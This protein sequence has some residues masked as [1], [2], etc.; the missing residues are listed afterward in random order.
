[1]TTIDCSEIRIVRAVHSAP[2]F[3]A[4]RDEFR[5]RF[6]HGFL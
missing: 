3:P 1:M 2:N 5:Q 4:L 6:V